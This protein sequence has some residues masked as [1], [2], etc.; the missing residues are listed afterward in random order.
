MDDLPLRDLHL[1]APIG[2][3]PLAPGWWLLAVTVLLMLGSA[4][5]W[6]RRR[7]RLRP[8]RLALSELD[9]LKRDLAATPA[10]RLQRLSILLRRVALTLY[11]REETASLTGAAWLRWLDAG[12]GTP[13][14]SEGPGR[15]LAEAPYRRLSEPV[16]EELFRLC[17]DWL[18]AQG[19]RRRPRLVPRR[20]SP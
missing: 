6:L 17:R 14:F 1:P 11:P 18:A 3:W 5:L 15:V 7:R 16:A 13:G 10:E 4:G 2:W 12:L 8:I 20:R 19:R 9:A